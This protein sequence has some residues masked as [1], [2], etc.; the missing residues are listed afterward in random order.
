MKKGNDGTAAMH[1]ESL[2]FQSK[3]YTFL[4]LWTA[5]TPNSE[6]NRLEAMSAGSQRPDWSRARVNNAS[7]KRDLYDF[8]HILG[9]LNIDRFSKFFHSCIKNQIYLIMDWFQW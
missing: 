2:I 9:S 5:L 8:A 1:V 7:Q 4:E 3:A 6:E